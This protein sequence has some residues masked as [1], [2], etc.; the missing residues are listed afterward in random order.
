[1]QDKM[2]MVRQRATALH[3]ID[4]LALRCGNEKDTDE[5]ADTVGCC[6][7]RVEHIELKDDNVV[8][9]DFLGKDRFVGRAMC[10]CSVRRCSRPGS[11]SLRACAAAAACGT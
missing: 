4:K 7:L 10:A 9:F 3:L 2:M 8:K 5:E 11:C 1:M 6:S